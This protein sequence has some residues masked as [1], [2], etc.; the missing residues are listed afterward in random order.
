VTRRRLDAEL[1][2]RGLATSRTE[3]QRMVQGGLV[4]VRDNPTP[5]PATQV[6]GGTSIRIREALHEY[7]SRGG[8]KLDHALAEFDVVVEGRSA[9]DVGASTGGFTDCL[10]HHGASTVAAVDVGYGQLIERLRS[11]PRVTVFDRCNIRTA[12]PSD[13]G[14]PFD[15]VV[16]DLSFIAICTVVDNL[17]RLGG[18]DADWVLLVKPQFEVGKADVGRGGIVRD[19]ML[20]A[21]AL[22]DATACLADVGL[23]VVGACASPITGAKSGN[24]EFLVHARRGAPTVGVA[25]FDRIVT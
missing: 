14:A 8:L 15:L 2:R 7:A 16:A 17:E 4:E 25:L 3:A 6:D 21:R 20:H 18:P 13:L 12:E 11:D 10:L 1:V 9:V 19:P 22:R 23:G 24:R 5:K